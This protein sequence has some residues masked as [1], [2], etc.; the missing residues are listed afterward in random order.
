MGKGHAEV[1]LII[2][3]RVASQIVPPVNIP[4]Q[5]LKWVL[6]WAVHLPQNGTIGFDTLLGVAR[7]SR[8]RVKSAGFG[9]CSI[10]QGAI[11]G[12]IL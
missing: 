10:C 8:A 6:K 5:P 12:T 1:A 7:D 4:I 3:P 9:L 11:V 2:W